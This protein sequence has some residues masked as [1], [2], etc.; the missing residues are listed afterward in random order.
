M[1]AVPVS[2]E[3]NVMKGG[4]VEDVGLGQAVEGL[5]PRLVIGHDPGGLHP[6]RTGADHHNLG[7]AHFAFITLLDEAGHLQGGVRRELE[8]I[9][10]RHEQQARKYV[11][12]GVSPLPTLRAP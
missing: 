4:A 12:Y 7:P 9:S 2:P 11:V 6:P 1:D 8:V 10:G 5:P 3:D